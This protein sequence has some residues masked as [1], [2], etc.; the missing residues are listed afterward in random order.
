MEVFGR[1]A[2]NSGT[3]AISSDELNNFGDIEASRGI[4]GVINN[5]KN[6][7]LLRTKGNLLLN[8]NFFNNGRFNTPRTNSVGRI[9]AFGLLQINN[10]E[11]YV[12]AGEIYS[13]LLAIISASSMQFLSTHRFYGCEADIR[14]HSITSDAGSKFSFQNILRFCSDQTSFRHYGDVHSSRVWPFPLL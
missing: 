5:F 8:T 6:Y 3:I 10:S 11:A 9:F 12:D 4:K 13:P 2:S 14:A 1:L 7:N